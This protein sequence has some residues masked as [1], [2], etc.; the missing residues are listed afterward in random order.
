MN[1]KIN[2]GGRGGGGERRDEKR[3]D[4]MNFFREGIVSDSK[5]II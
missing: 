2:R 1:E 3:G 5:N 4:S